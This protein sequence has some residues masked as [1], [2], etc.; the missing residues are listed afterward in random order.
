VQ[1]EVNG[2]PAWVSAQYLLGT[3]LNQLNIT[4]P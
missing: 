2:R 1:T 3:P 4:R